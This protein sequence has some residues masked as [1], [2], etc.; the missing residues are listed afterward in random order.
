MLTIYLHRHLDKL[1]IDN[2][3]LSRII[4]C[5]TNR[6]NSN[7]YTHNTDIIIITDSNRFPS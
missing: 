1:S 2:Y 5:K 4:Y 3:L 7:I 6:N